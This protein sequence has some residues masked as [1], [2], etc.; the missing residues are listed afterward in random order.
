MY[1]IINIAKDTLYDVLKLSPLQNLLSYQQS[2]LPALVLSTK[3][4]KAGREIL[5]RLRF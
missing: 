3:N 1:S 2:A 4:K 5:V